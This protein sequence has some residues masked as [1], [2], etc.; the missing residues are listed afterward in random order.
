MIKPILLL[1]AIAALIVA[2][3]NKIRGKKES[4]L[5]EPIDEPKRDDGPLVIDD[6]DATDGDAY[7]FKI[8]TLFPERFVAIDFETAT[9]SKMA[10]QLGI[11]E[12]ENGRIILESRFL[13]RPPGNEYDAMTIAVHGITAETTAD[14]PTFKELWPKILPL[15]RGQHVVAHN[16]SFDKAVLEANLK[17]YDLPDPEIADFA[18]TCGP[19]GNVSL[20]SAA[21]Y[22]N[23][24]LDVHHDALSDARACALLALELN[25][26][27]GET[28][29][30][31]KLNEKSI[32]VI[33][34]EN[35]GWADDFGEIPDNPFKGKTI[36]ITGTLDSY[37]SRDDLAGLLKGLGARVTSAISRKTSIV[38]MGPGAGPAKLEKIEE[39]Q[40]AGAEIEIV[41]EDDLVRKLKACSVQNL[42]QCFEQNRVK[43]GSKLGENAPLHP[44]SV[45]ENQ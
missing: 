4:R 26:H 35:K 3:V 5:D 15:L 42:N 12:V 31:P 7:V 23:I 27:F 20:Y 24:G 30:V 32:K 41:H 38:I 40:A 36:V 39:L 8:R 25:R 18:C 45:I 21:R 44:K 2:V 13:I 19:F 22:F 9:A 1:A 43:T 33:S 16:V 14:A 11:A 37:P 29:H 10:C 6:Q 34:K 17:Y 28:L